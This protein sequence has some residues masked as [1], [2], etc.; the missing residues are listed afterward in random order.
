[1]LPAVRAA[2]MF[3]DR[4]QYPI[5]APVAAPPI[6]YTTLVIGVPTDTICAEL[7]EVKVIVG[8]GFT[9]IVYELDA[10]IPNPV[11]GVTVIV[12]VIGNSVVFVAVNEAISPVPDDERPIAE[13]LL[14]QVNVAPEGVLAKAVAA[15]VLPL[16]TV[17]FAGTVTVEVGSEFTVIIPVAVDVQVL[18]A[19][20]IVYVNGLP[21]DVVG[22][23]DILNPPP[24][25]IPVTPG[26]RP[27]IA[28]P[29]AP[30]NS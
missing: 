9:M 6:V 26:G 2:D 13:L 17:T 7:P 25:K 4:T 14:V 1:V 5:P 16:H 11:V 23:P 18:P 10:P 21:N 27:V 8:V 15:T 30:P 24:E 28:A 29:V 19:V 20:V 3:A 12:A 22:V